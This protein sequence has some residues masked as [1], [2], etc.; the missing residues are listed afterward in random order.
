MRIFG[1]IVRAL[2]NVATLPVAVIKDVVTLGGVASDNG[3]P[4]IV[5]KLKQIKREAE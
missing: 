4:F 1:Q 5:S 3:E 2:V